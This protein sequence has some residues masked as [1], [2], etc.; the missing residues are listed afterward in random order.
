MKDKTYERDKLDYRGSQ[1]PRDGF[2]PSYGQ[3]PK[4]WLKFRTDGPVPILF[5]EKIRLI[6]NN[7]IGE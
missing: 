1:D 5:E 7:M 4:F 6:L 2:W 3:L